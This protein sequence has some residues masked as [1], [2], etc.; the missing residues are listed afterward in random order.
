MRLWHFTCGD[1][2]HARIGARGVLRPNLHPLIRALGPIVW[3]TDD[4][5]P[6][7]DAVGLT[8]SMISCDRLQYRYRALGASVCT[9]WRAFRHRVSPAVLTDLESFGEPDSW[10]VCFR[11]L[12]VVLDDDRASR[13][14]AA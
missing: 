13:Q 4:P 1:H 3:L 5:D 2:G 10:W 11:P 9:P 14:V 8:S 6:T 7:R 12:R